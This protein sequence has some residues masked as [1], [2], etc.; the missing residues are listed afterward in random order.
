[1]QKHVFLLC[2]QC[3]FVCRLW[4]SVSTFVG[5]RAA[6]LLINTDQK[7]QCGRNGPQTLNCLCLP[8]AC[9]HC[10]WIYSVQPQLSVCYSS[11]GYDC[12]GVRHEGIVPWFVL[13]PG[14]AL[15]KNETEIQSSFH[16]LDLC[17][18]PR[19]YGVFD[20]KQWIRHCRVTGVDQ[21]LYK[22]SGEMEMEIFMVILCCGSVKLI[23][24]SLSMSHLF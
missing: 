20:L 13:V 17:W 5:T 2:L 22:I 10:C 11:W 8:R 4:Q 9:S 24:A 18:N 3:A 16:K 23:S 12:R 7:P 15:R 14:C 21:P 19:Q 1:M 6:E